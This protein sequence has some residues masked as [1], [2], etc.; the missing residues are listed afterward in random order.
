M[1]LKTTLAA[2]S[3]LTN[4][5]ESITQITKTPKDRVLFLNMD[6]QGQEETDVALNIDWTRK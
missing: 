2:F 6:E 1:Y 5:K 3:W 4:W